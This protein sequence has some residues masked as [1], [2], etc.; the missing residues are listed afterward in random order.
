[1]GKE[2]PLRPAAAAP[3]AAAEEAPADLAGMLTDV[4]AAA[5][6]AAASTQV[7]KVEESGPGQAAAEAPASGAPGGGLL[8]DR[9]YYREDDTQR[10]HPVPEAERVRGFRV[11]SAAAAPAAHAL[12]APGP[13][14]A[15]ELRRC[16]RGAPGLLTDCRRAPGPECAVRQ[17]V[18][19]G[20]ARGRR[21]RDVPGA[22]GVPAA[23]LPPRRRHPPPLLH[24]CESRGCR[25]C[26]R[27]RRV[28]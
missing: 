2:T 18:R 3:K 14:A 25:L 24:G 28:H 27:R 23:G 12:C 26:R 20:D 5:A 17:A 6:A 9:E 19:A 4:A 1:M 11:S 22:K 21:G 10:E 15:R 7:T 8:T 13:L 16:T